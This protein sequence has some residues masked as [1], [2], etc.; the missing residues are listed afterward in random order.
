[1]SDL[2]V[3]L[4]AGASHDGLRPGAERPP[5]AENLFDERYDD[6]QELFP[7][8]DVIR[9]TILA[10]MKQGQSLERILGRL[11]QNPEPTIQRQ[12]LEVPI[13]L[14]RLLERFS[15]RRPGTYDELITLIREAQISVTFVT[16]NY[17]ILLE[18]AIANGYGSAI[19]SIDD[20]VDP[21][22]S[23]RWNCV[24]LHGSVDWRYRTSIIREEGSNSPSS[25]DQLSTAGVSIGHTS[26]E[27]ITMT[28]FDR[29]PFDRELTYPALAVPTDRTKNIVCPDRHVEV[30]RGALRADP[31]IL[32]IG[33]Q[34]LDEDL[35]DILRNTKRLQE[36]WWDRDVG[37]LVRVAFSSGKPFRVVDPSNGA[38]VASRFADALGRSEFTIPRDGVGFRDFVESEEADR[39]FEEVRVASR[40]TTPQQSPR[41]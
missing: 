17:D 23:R 11:A 18:R 14:Q 7:G 41:H 26:G 29:N 30:L 35:M 9:N 32:V 2:L 22:F 5:L 24:K 4:G 16:L 27:P 12:M 19:E 28:D 38:E 3:V 20:Y 31:A 10:R 13:Y 40:S 39:F 8:V 37:E 25:L 15:G 1:M 34:G 33:N 6:L 21:S 36:P